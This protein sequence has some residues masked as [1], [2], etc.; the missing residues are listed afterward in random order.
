MTNPFALLGFPTALTLAPA[1]ID[2]AWR[3]GSRSGQDEDE[4]ISSA[5]NEARTVLSDPVGRLAA[6]L[7]IKAPSRPQDNA[8]APELMDLFAKIGPVLASTDGLLARH[9]RATTA[10]AR[11]MLAKEAVAAQL[12]VQGLL[13]EIQP[14]KSALIDRFPEFEALAESGDF[15]EAGRC[16]VQL[17]FL[18]RWESQCQERLLT[19]LA[20]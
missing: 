17:K 6:W 18:K 14:L 9:R 7:G 20:A 12:A 19:L 16:L 8:I 5:R 2:A 3:E 11:A 10:L 13:R 4:A 15:E 1:E